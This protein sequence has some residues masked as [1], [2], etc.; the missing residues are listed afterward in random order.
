LD[1]QAT[2]PPV[3]LRDPDGIIHPLPAAWADG[4][5]L[6]CIGHSECGTTRLALPF[7]DR[8]RQRLGAGGSVLAILQDEPAAARDFVQALALSLP[9]RL[10]ED[11]YPVAT[12]LRL[13]TVPTLLLVEADGRVVS[14][15]EGFRRADFESFAA[16]LGVPGSLFAAAD[17]APALRPG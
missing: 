17:Q 6:V 10:D 15:S 7:V 13:T 4:P 2:L 16:R 8:I 12:A 9:V 11:P 14:Y 1:P 3:S 5:A